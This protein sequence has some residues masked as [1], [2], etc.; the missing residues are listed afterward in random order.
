MDDTSSQSSV[1][2]DG[3]FIVNKLDQRL[4][5]L[6]DNVEGID[7]IKSKKKKKKK[8]KIKF[9]YIYLYTF[10]YLFYFLFF[11]IY[12]LFCNYFVIIILK[13]FIIFNK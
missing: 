9:N 12:I 6:Y 11:I 1:E 5:F 3:S 10:I 2:T 8:K 13:Y 7:V 4:Q